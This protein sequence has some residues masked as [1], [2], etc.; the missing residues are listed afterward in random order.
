M[1]NLAKIMIPIIILLIPGLWITQGWTG[2]PNETVGLPI[3]FSALGLIVISLILLMVGSAPGPT[4]GKPVKKWVL[5]I[6][7]KLGMY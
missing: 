5:K 1:A 2:E 6:L 4:E 7:T 3:L